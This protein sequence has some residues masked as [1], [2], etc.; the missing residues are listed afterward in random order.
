MIYR[1]AAKGWFPIFGRGDVNY[2]PN[3]VDNLVDAFLLAQDADPKVNG[4]AYLIADESY[5]SIKDLVRRAG[6]AI[7]V[8][9]KI[10]R[11]S[12][13]ARSNGCVGMRA[14]VSPFADHPSHLPA[15]DRLVPAEPSLLDSTRPV[16]T[17][18]RPPCLD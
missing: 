4:R 11:L 17:G 6:I 16:R 15:P 9:V 2:H 8:D 13:A 10:C 12:A 18:I 3:Y 5:S 14:D 1:Q 7:G